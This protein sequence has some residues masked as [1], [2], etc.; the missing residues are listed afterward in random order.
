MAT[1]G[2]VEGILRLRNEFS[3]QLDKATRDLDQATAKME[4]AGK[5]ATT[6]SGTLDQAGMSLDRV[7]QQSR[8]AGEGLTQL[9]D[10]VSNAGDDMLDAEVKTNR[11]AAVLGL[12]ATVAIRARQDLEGIGEELDELSPKASQFGATVQEMFGDTFSVVLTGPLAAFRIWLREVNEELT[13]LVEQKKIQELGGQLGVLD[14]IAISLADSLGLLP[15]KINRLGEA[16]ALQREFAIADA[17]RAMREETERSAE[18]TIGDE[19]TLGLAELEEAVQRAEALTSRLDELGRAGDGARD[20]LMRLRQEYKEG[21]AAIKERRMEEELFAEALRMVSQESQDQLDSA[22]ELAEISSSFFEAIDNDILERQAEFMREFFPKRVELDTLDEF[23]KTLEDIINLQGFAGIEILSDDDIERARA[24]IEELRE[25]GDDI[26]AK[27]KD[28]GLQFAQTIGQF[29]SEFGQITSAII[30][31]VSAIQAL[32]VGLN[33]A[34]VSAEGAAIAL[35]ALDTASVILAVVAALFQLA[36]A[37]EVFGLG[38]EDTG[39]RLTGTFAIG[40]FGAGGPEFGSRETREAFQKLGA[41]VEQGIRDLFETTG[42]VWAEGMTGL[43]FE[44]EAIVK[45]GQE[46]FRVIFEDGFSEVFDS[47]EEAAGFALQQF[48]QELIRQGIEFDEAVRQFFE[49]FSGDLEMFGDNLDRVQGLADDA[50]L[51]LGEVSSEFELNVSKLPGLIA[52]LTR[53]LNQLG[54]QADQVTRLVGGQIVQFFQQARQQITGERLSVEE[55]RKIAEAQAE[56]FN[57]EL[58]LQIA[59]LEAE[60]QALIAEAGIAKQSAQ[61]DGNIIN[62]QAR[63]V[64]S[65]GT[66]ANAELGVMKGFVQTGAAIVRSGVELI[67]DTSRALGDALGML[68]EEIRKQ[69]EAIQKVIDALRKIGTISP[70]DIRIPG[71]IGAGG[72]GGAGGGGGGGGPSGPTLEEVIGDLIDVVLRD[73]ESQQQLITALE[74]SLTGLERFIG[75]LRI[76]QPSPLTAGQQ[77]ALLRDRLADAAGRALEGDVEAIQEFQR[78]AQQLRTIGAQAFGTA[79]SGFEALLREIE[80]LGGDILTEGNV[81]L[82]NELDALQDIRNEFADL[83]LLTQDLH[84]LTAEQIAAIREGTSAELGGVANIIQQLAQ[85]QSGTRQ[86]LRELR[87]AIIALGR[88]LADAA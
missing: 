58:E 26:N 63:F 78:I 81:L 25:G 87:D 24:F 10:S 77:V 7:D 70:G 9:G 84:D 33:T 12:L 39:R 8:R 34:T 2:T 61:L 67:G 83:L 46:R 73:I 1:I 74:D 52:S 17:L 28:V 62:A 50:A 6:F 36:Q 69:V 72:V 56:L 51:A 60:K 49:G 23:E 20:R 47:A 55:R 27:W 4:R 85:G 43:T 13:R 65:R 57:A 31:T 59:R 86:D 68:P 37:L 38:G 19:D 14:R 71:A 21:I 66:L 76:G 15:E 5:G 18:L 29:D 45:G 53:E 80:R 82:E 16:A 48:G 32:V 54:L 11:M 41:Q 42:A 79:G 3:S 75:D 44:I 88:I 35:K 30:T 64:Q 40:E 22:Q